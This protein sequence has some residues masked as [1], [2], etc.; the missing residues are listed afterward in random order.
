MSIIKKNKHVKAIILH[1]AILLLKIIKQ[2][3][4]ALTSKSLECAIRV[5]N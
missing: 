5:E 1:P 4:G 2:F 3:F